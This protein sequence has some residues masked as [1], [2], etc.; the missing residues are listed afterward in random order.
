MAS[1]SHDLNAKIGFFEK[2][3]TILI[4]PRVYRNG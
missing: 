1:V 4:E 2:G 3:K